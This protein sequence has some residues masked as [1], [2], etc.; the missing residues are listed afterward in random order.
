MRRLWYRITGFFRVE[1]YLMW[2]RYHQKRDPK[3]EYKMKRLASIRNFAYARKMRDFADSVEFVD[4][5]DYTQSVLS[6]SYRRMLLE[7]EARLARV[8][9]LLGRVVPASSGQPIKIYRW[10]PL[11]EVE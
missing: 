6:F 4:R 10:E 1:A 5:G 2:Y 11:P 9:A 8:D 7:R 3:W